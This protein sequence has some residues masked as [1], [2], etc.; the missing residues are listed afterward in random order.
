MRIDS[1]ETEASQ[2][3]RLL[4][5]EDA[6]IERA[7]LAYLLRLRGY[8]V[9]ESADGDTAIQSLTEGKF[10]LLLLDLS[11]PGIDGFDVLRF[12]QKQKPETRVILLSGTSPEKIQE[13]LTDLPGHVLPPLLLKPVD[14][15]Q[16]YDLVEMQ[17]SGQLDN[18][19]CQTPAESE[20]KTGDQ[21]SHN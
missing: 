2:R 20:N 12:V 19:N 11:L 7:G 8:D 21:F 16:V 3:P 10:D 17:L 14:P 1:A 5:C 13:R 6:P 15:E 18:L 4:I 9:C